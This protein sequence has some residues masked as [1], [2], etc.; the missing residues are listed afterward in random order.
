MPAENRQ[1]ECGEKTFKSL[2]P[3]SPHN[4]DG[5]H[6]LYRK[7]GLSARFFKVHWL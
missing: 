1:A 2:S 3:K 6:S 5:K 4:D 7:A